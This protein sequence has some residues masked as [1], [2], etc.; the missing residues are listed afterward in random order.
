MGLDRDDFI[1]TIDCL[2][3]DK[4]KLSEKHKI[5]CFKALSKLK[6]TKVSTFNNIR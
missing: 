6:Q 2:L 3:W 1:F 5:Q 4:L